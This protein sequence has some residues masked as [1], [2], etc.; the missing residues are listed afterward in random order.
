MARSVQKPHSCRFGAWRFGSRSA[1]PVI[2]IAQHPIPKEFKLSRVRI[3]EGPFRNPKSDKNFRKMA[4]KSLR[5]SSFSRL[6]V[7]DAK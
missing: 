7:H 5:E 6:Q 1:R 4:R 2:N 3:Q